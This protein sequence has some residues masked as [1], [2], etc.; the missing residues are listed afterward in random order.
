MSIITRQE[1]ERLVIELYNQG[2][3]FRE[4]AKEARMSFRD[5]GIILNKV[6]E[7]EKTEGSKEG[8]QQ[9]REHLSLSTQAYKL[10]SEGKSPIEVAVA[11]NL[12][13]PEATKLYREYWK[14]KR[15]HNL[16]LIYEELGE[17]N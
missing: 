3:T 11:L 5:I 2:K 7:E 8:E 16:N 10:F 12:G 14:L 1:R 6:V 13:E 17:E 15:L 4:I 9:E